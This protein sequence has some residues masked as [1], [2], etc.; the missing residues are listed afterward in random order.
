MLVWL[1]ARVVFTP[2]TLTQ[3]S[4]L[5]PQLSDAESFD[6]VKCATDCV[7]SLPADGMAPKK[8]REENYD[9]VMEMEKL[10]RETMDAL[11]ALLKQMLVKN[12]TPACLNDMFKVRGCWHS[13]GVGVEEELV[14]PASLRGFSSV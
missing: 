5:D 8:G 9:E 1:V 2:I 12:P 6:L 13:G 3:G 14:C 11:H 7:F 4:K 10:L